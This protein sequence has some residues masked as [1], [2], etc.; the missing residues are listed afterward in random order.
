MKQLSLAVFLLALAGCGGESQ[1]T[2]QP[3]PPSTG[4]G[5]FVYQGP[6]AKTE[7]IQKFKI[8]FWDNIVSEQRCGACHNENG[9]TPRFARRD[10]INLAYSEINGL[11]NLQTPAE[12][13]L[14]SKVKGGHNCWLTSDNACADIL[15]TW[16]GNWAATDASANE[17]ELTDPVIKEPGSSKRFPQ[18][19]ALFASTV[20]P[21]VR[22]NCVNCHASSANFPIGPYFAEAD[23]DAAY[24][25]AQS[26]IDLNQPAL[27]RFVLRLG[28][29]F[30]N[31]WG[32]CSDNAA[33]ML[34][35][36]TQFAEGVPTDQVDEQL[37][38][39]K[40]L[41]LPDGIIASSGSRFEQNIIAKWEFK[42]GSGTVAYDTS[43][44]EPA[45]DL[46]LN[47]QVNWVGG[48]GV[49]FINGRAQA[50]TA[51]SKKL[52]DMLTATGEYS[53][54][55]WLTPN[56]VTQEGPARIISYSG[57]LDRRNFT[58]GQTLYN[59]NYLLRN[60]GSDE[61]G[62]PMLSTRDAAEVLQASLQH[63]VMNF[64]PVNGRSLYVNGE[65][66]A[67]DDAPE[68]AGLTNWDPSF[69]LILA[70]ETSGN[71]P[72]AGAIRMLAVHNRSLNSEQ[73][74]QNFS[75]GVGERFY[76]L[77][78]VSDLINISRAYIVLEV[79]QF[80]S[81][82]YLFKE[83]FFISLD[84]ANQPQNIPIKGMRI[85]INGAESKTGQAFANLDTLL[86]NNYSPSKGQS[87]S[88]LGTL[89][90]LQ[91]GP[92]LDEFFLT[93]ER[94]GEHENVWLE[95]SVPSLP[96]PSDLTPSSHIGIKRFAEI[97]A[98]F[99]K[100]TT[101]PT[102]NNAVNASY[103]K[104]IQQLPSVSKIDTFVAANQMAISQLA[105]KYCS[106]LMNDTT[107]RGNY[108]PNVDFSQ[109]PNIT[110]ATN[111]RANFITPLLDKALGNNVA[112][113]P[114]RTTLSGEINALMDR[115]DQC[116]NQ[117]NSQRTL[118]IAKASCAA[119]IGSATSLIK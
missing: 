47:G 79:S 108:F 14:V 98:T 82:S 72:W 55:A 85:G 116:P 4:G 96:E 9:Q 110:F 92:Q 46:N 36:I 117:C 87:L 35:A 77:F 112:T 15:V 32:N 42:T 88:A 22:T 104:L 20:Y 37:V 21:I 97:N 102:S 30:H 115:L 65:L 56:N 75:V 118:T 1:V 41:S 48:W 99:A 49:N 66:V 51:S 59:Y 12:S 52:Y 93:F 67:N 105:I 94:L 3:I 26:K 60:S 43:G 64:D 84:S 89:I 2:E 58:L 103:Q 31:C 34:N 71:R 81:Y 33:T 23:V 70:N 107:L 86:G 61:N 28:N 53:I 74:K 29:E 38:I 76:L 40:A 78:G 50:S 90:G 54:E 39:S 80:D 119:V 113:G 100:I 10:D 45:M 19:S 8:A 18:S 69:A 7:D 111:A 109:A 101:V 24:Q 11:V 114:E 91:N 73:I 63:V 106:E 27:S 95:P 83:P 6:A 62:M 68:G 17:I 44:V 5:D 16:L 13:L 25:A 57:G